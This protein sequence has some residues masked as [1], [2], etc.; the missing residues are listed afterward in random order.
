MTATK[1]SPETDPRV[2]RLRKR[3]GFVGG[4]KRAERQ[5]QD[6]DAAWKAFNKQFRPE[7]IIAAWQEAK[8]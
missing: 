7:R 1:P 5:L 2:I 4:Y 6:E 8:W 3:N